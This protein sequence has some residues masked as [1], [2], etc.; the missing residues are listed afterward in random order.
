MHL[1]MVSEITA[2]LLLCTLLCPLRA[3]DD[4]RTREELVKA[5]QAKAEKVADRILALL[6][7]GHRRRS[8]KT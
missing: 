7:K 8:R 6:K 5:C 2:A 3:Q 4:T 1:K